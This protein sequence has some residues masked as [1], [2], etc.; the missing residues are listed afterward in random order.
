MNRSTLIDII[1]DVQLRKRFST[2]DLTG[3]F[4]R[5]IA[6]CQAN[7]NAFITVTS[8]LALAD[9]VRADQRLARSNEA[10][11][12]PGLIVAIKDNIDVGGVRCTVGSDF[13]KDRI[14]RADAD[15]VR[16]LRASGA[17]IVGK[18]LLHEFAF[19]TTTINPHF[20]VC[21]NP[22]NRDRIAGGSSGG[23]AAAVA[24]DLCIAGL[25][26]DTGGSIRIPAALTGV[27]GL[28]PTVGA[29][30]TRGV[31]P[32]SYTFDTVG[33]LARSVV[34]IA[35]LHR[36]I[37]GF[38]ELDPSSVKHPIVD[39]LPQ[40]DDGIGGLRVGV[41][42]NY[43]FSDIQPDVAQAVRG[44][45]EE[46]ARLGADVT[47]LVVRGVEDVATAMA[48][49]REAEAL[50]VHRERLRTHPVRFGEDVANRL[51]MGFKS[52]AVDFATALRRMHEW[53]AYLRSLFQDVNLLLCPTTPLTAPPL[54]NVLEQTSQALIRFTAPFSFGG[55]PTI[56][57][58]CGFD[59][60]QLPIGLQ[61]I[62]R[63]WD[64]ATLLRCSFA[65]QSVTD[66][67]RRR[68]QND[69]AS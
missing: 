53:R 12:L 68:P 19:G 22:W 60:E 50:Y 56:S 43:F 62:A 5:R 28:R 13:F 39:P 20:G 32:V 14:S 31:F 17:A 2:T 1:D 34:D 55:V 40:M 63:P 44:A 61:L 49:I 38:D 57:I 4:L 10:G 27:S 54:D 24:A 11:V 42:R 16:R 37:A 41:P 48:I 69:C 8:D 52:T 18:T 66:W 35:V 65:Y 23:S 33:P 30:S 64:E 6:S 3:S 59:G 25:G 29:V 26:T 7:L 46:L 36:V 67:H 45:A 9:A 47:E 21:R 15:V 51:R 58:P